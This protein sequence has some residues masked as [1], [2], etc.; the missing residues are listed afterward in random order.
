[1]GIV[2]NVVKR[3]VISHHRRSGVVLFSDT[4]L[5]DGEQ[6]PGATLDPQDK[7]QIA[8]ALEQLGVHSIDAGFAASSEAD[9]EAMRLMVNVIRKPVL[10]SLCRT[11]ASDVD[12]AERALDG[13]PPHKKGVS[14]FCGT[15]PLHRQHKLRKNRPQ[16]LE[17]IDHT[18]R[19]AASKF[20]IVAFSP[21]DASRTEPDFLCECY[22]TAIA[23]GATTVG[24]P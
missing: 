18:V 22:Q 6:M 8:M 21:E 4:T 19:Y 2:G 17:L 24:F 15:S 3:M 16:I 9:V 12:A 7:L 10:T 14:L 1:M 13:H 20:Q 23:A 11:I 5:R